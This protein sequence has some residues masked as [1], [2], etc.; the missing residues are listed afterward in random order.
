MCQVRSLRCQ[1]SWQR[2]ITPHQSPVD[3]IAP[4]PWSSISSVV[5]ELSQVDGVIWVAS[6]PRVARLD[7]SMTICHRWR[8]SFPVIFMFRYGSRHHT[9]DSCGPDLG[10]DSSVADC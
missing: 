4:P 1:M 10:R 7:I 9:P 6:R 5:S 8:F 2:L 3:A